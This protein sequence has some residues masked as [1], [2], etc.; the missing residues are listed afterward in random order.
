MIQVMAVILK[1]FKMIELYS[2]FFQQ[3]K[4]VIC[5]LYNNTIKF[6]LFRCHILSHIITFLCVQ[7]VI[8]LKALYSSINQSLI[9]YCIHI[10]YYIH[11]L[12]SKICILLTKKNSTRH[13]RK[14]TTIKITNIYIY[15]TN[16]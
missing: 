13:E 3:N 15:N 8:K 12:T 1:Q 9:H 4:Q 11:I 16:Y 5:N 10:T 7:K 2:I 14:T 6:I